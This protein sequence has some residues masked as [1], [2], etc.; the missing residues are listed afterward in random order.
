M[1]PVHAQL[2]PSKRSRFSLCPGSA[3]YPDTGT[4]GPAAID[5]THSHTLLERC[6]KAGLADPLGMIGVTLEDHDGT[7]TVDA[8]R[9]QRV[10]VAVEYIRSRNATELHAETRVDPARLVG[11]SDMAGTIDALVIAPDV[12]E[13]VD[14]KDGMHHVPATGNPQL[15]QYAV[16]VLAEYPV[17]PYPFRTVRLTII[18]P[19]LATKGMAPIDTWETTVDDILDRVVPRLQREGAAC[20]DPGAPRIPGDVQCRYCPIKGQCPELA[21]HTLNSAG[22]AFPTVTEAPALDIVDQA[23]DKD[24]TTMTAEQIVRI[25]EAEPLITGML[26]AVKEEALKRLQA[27]PGSVP[28]LKLV[29]GRGSRRW[30]L[31]EDQMAVVLKK[32]G[33]PKESIWLTE[34]TSPA[35]A[36]K[37]VWKN[38]AGEQVTLSDKKRKILTKEYVTT[39]A[40]KPTV[41]LASDERPALVTDA[42]ALFSAIE[43][44]SAPVALPAAPEALPSWL[45]F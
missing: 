12:L 44:P 6:I 31:P 14:Y 5:G 11:R 3:K 4:A 18:Q 23:A 42:S 9:A 30:A 1:N 25:I 7:F 41:A 13:I 17:R 2:S 8:D 29:S 15:E 19:K 27:N 28:G 39:V 24:P 10:K 37:A 34:L 45:T 33:M 40:G 38:R 16:G 36:E 32:L 21:A 26:A 22:I 43:A 20:D 35:K